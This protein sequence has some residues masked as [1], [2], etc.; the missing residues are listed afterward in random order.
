MPGNALPD[1]I[2]ALL[3]AVRDALRSL[4]AA[5]TDS[6]E[7]QCIARAA[8]AGPDGAR[9][10]IES[11]GGAS[12]ASAL[13]KTSASFRATGHFRQSDLI[14]RLAFIASGWERRAHPRRR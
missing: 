11:T 5:A 1:D 6:K 7:L 14:E 2:F 10:I 9:A 13:L 8:K 3:T 4:P 12:V